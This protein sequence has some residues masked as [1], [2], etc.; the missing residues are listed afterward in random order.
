[1]MLYCLGILERVM[2]DLE[3]MVEAWSNMTS[4]LPQPLGPVCLKL[5]TQDASGLCFRRSTYGSKANLI[6][7]PMQVVSRQKASRIN[8]NHRNNL[9]YRIYQGAATLSFGPMDR[10]SCLGPL[11]EHPGVLHDP[12]VFINS[13]CSSIRVGIL[14]RLFCQEQFYRSS[15]CETPTL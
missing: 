10:V 12:R 3:D 13:C 14:L 6:R 8:G 1:M 5:V 11:G 4:S 7:K 2:K 15:I 9:A